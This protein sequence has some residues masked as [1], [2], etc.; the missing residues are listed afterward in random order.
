MT[1]HDEALQARRY[2]EVLKDQKKRMTIALRREHQTLAQLEAAASVG[3]FDAAKATARDIRAGIVRNLD[4]Q[5]KMNAS[6]LEQAERGA[7]LKTVA[8]EM[9][10]RRLAPVFKVSEF[11][12]EKNQL[13][14]SFRV[15][16]VS[17]CPR[18]Q[19]Q[20]PLP[21]AHSQALRTLLPG[22]DLPIEC[23]RYAAIGALGAP[24]DKD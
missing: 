20:C 23:Q 2:L 14:Y 3:E 12:G 18:Y 8:A 9:M 11:K 15:D 16:F 6:Y 24:G 19:Y 10:R 13:G 17:P 1:R 21:E 4:E 7:E 22:Q 5:L